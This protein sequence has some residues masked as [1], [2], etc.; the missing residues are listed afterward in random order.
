M[1][2]VFEKYS[3]SKAFLCKFTSAPVSLH[4]HN[5][6]MQIICIV[7]DP[8]KASHVVCKEIW[9]Y[10]LL[11]Q[12]CSRMWVVPA[13][14]GGVLRRIGSKFQFLFIHIIGKYYFKMFSRF[15]VLNSIL[16]K[17]FEVFRVDV[18]TPFQHNS[19]DSSPSWSQIFYLRSY[20][21]FSSGRENAKPLYKMLF[22]CNL[23]HSVSV[24]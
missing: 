5:N 20:S 9:Q 18:I 22:T 8:D 10:M 24:M 11:E 12:L 23:A 1:S 13:F 4:D 2:K 21:K 17:Y 6:T 19:S 14:L 7:F 16:K 15:Y 3:L